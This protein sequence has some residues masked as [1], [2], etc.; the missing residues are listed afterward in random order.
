MY[1]I[2]ILLLIPVEW[3]L[4]RNQSHQRE[5]GMYIYTAY[6]RYSYIFL[7][8]RDFPHVLHVHTSGVIPIYM[9]TYVYCTSFNDRAT[10]PFLFTQYSWDDLT[11]TSF[12]RAQYS[13]TRVYAR[14]DLN[15]FIFIHFFYPPP[16]PPGAMAV[17]R[18]YIFHTAL[19]I[20]TP[21]KETEIIYNTTY[22]IK[23][24]LTSPKNG[25]FT[26][27]PPL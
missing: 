1:K 24:E 8:P 19:G 22:R 16:S 26:W 14:H 10:R 12:L 5:S 25:F 4:N 20:F 21:H 23:E 15:L 13:P 18:R 27:P 11:V 6:I 3:S 17:R 9:Y 2:V 7:R